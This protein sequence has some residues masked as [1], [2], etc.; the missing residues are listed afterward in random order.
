[1]GHPPAWQSVLILLR[2]RGFEGRF[3]IR[4]TSHRLVKYNSVLVCIPSLFGDQRLQQHKVIFLLAE[5]V[6]DAGQP[7]CLILYCPDQAILVLY[8][9]LHL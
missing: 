4:Q 1:M 8:L 5:E 7:A 3:R 6:I 2:Q 9:A